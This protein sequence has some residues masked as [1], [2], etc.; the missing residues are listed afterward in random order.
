MLGRF[1]GWAPLA[2]GLLLGAVLVPAAALAHGEKGEHVASFQDHLDD[3]EADV[4]ELASRL[5]ELVERYRRDSEAVDVDELVEAWEEV[6]YHA[7]VE[8]VATPLYPAIWQAIGGLRQAVKNGEDA[9][10]VRAKADRMVAAL[11]EGL[12]G[13][14]L[15][16]RMQKA[17]GTEGPDGDTASGPHAAFE[18]IRQHLDEAV[19]AYDGGDPEEAKALIRDAY[20]NAFEGLEGGLIEEDPALVA[21]LEEAFNAGLPGRINEGA[22]TAKVR[23]KV[24]SMK[25]ELAE[26]EALLEGSGEEDSEVF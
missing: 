22:A 25:E 5:D 15:K 17:T 21:R 16:A 9:E 12:G 10:T 14:K 6:E 24:A 11:R 4:E 23:A 13:L 20:F 7:A 2:I 8:E 1:D 19:A 26:A 3:Y 18:R